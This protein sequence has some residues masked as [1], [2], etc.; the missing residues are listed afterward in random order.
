M[1]TTYTDK[2]KAAIDDPEVIS[3]YLCIRNFLTRVVHGKG[4]VRFFIV[5]NGGSAATASHM[6]IDLM[7]CT[8]KRIRMVSLTD[9]AATTAIANDFS[10][11]EIFSYQLEIQAEAGDVLIVLSV[12]GNSPNI[13]EAMREATNKN[14]TVVG[15][16]G[17]NVSYAN[18]TYCDYAVVVPS[19]EYGIVEDCHAIMLH[20][21]VEELKVA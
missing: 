15:F 17:K 9:P 13:V 5:G 6:A 3:N 14:M 2:L 19:S 10:F 16:F 1:L 4:A 12:S 7:K 20:S 8:D 11:S 18:R 21:L